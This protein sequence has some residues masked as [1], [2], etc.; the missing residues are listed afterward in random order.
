M[1]KVNELRSQRAKAWDQ[2]KAFL[3]SHRNEKGILSAED[4]AAYEKME[5]EIVDLGH[6]I[7]RQERMDA[8][9]RE[10]AAPVNTPITAKPESRKVDEKVGRASDSYK[11]AFWSQARAKDGVSYEIRNALSEGVD[12]EGGYLVPD[13]FE[14]TLISALGEAN[15]VREHAHVFST[16]NGTHK[17]PVVVS[18]GTAAWIDE[19]G[20][21]TEADDV[22]GIEQIDAHKVG[23][24][25]KVSEELLYDSA[26][27]LEAYFREEFARRIGDCEEDA[28]LNGNGSKKPTG[29]LNST[30]G[31][32]IGIT[33][34]SATAITAD[35]LIDL[36]YSVKSPYRKN[37]VWVLND[38]TVR[39]IRKLKDANGQYLWQPALREGE[40]DTIL[41][42]R[43][44]TSPFMPTAAA[45]AKTIL[46]GDLSYY[47]I[48]DRQGVTFK[49]LNERY[50]D[51]GQVGFLASKRVDGKLVLP[52]A[53][54]VLQQKPGSSS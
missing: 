35:E 1:S 19:N 41:G 54:K 32:E 34:A 16:S 37:A 30:G 48:G 22:F 24:I 14:K 39:L 13:E 9:E 40:F 5:Q 45:G 11:K 21:Y 7:E 17:I 20:A 46:F 52:E 36:F 28:F 10:L 18:K 43:I 50:A 23:T 26:F 42:K 2:A 27:D 15:A 6:E 3:D 33:A 29:L 53:V 12:S 47:W 51:M 31:A 8:L 4:T 25:I 49:R 38:A 44:Y